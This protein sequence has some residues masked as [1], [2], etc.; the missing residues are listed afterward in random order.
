MM[1]CS[2]GNIRFSFATQSIPDIPGNLISISTTSGVLAGIAFKPPPQTQGS[3]AVDIGRRPNIRILLTQ[4]SIVLNNNDRFIHQFV[5]K[6]D[7]RNEC[8][9]PLDSASLAVACMRIVVPF[10]SELSILQRPPLA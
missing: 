8:F 7:S 6:P 9:S 3:N 10:P 4:C 2:D 1:I 5:A